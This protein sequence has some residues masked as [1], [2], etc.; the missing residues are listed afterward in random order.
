MNKWRLV[1]YTDDGCSLFQC[2]NCKGRWES[3]GAPGFTLDEVYHA[4]WKFCPIC[5]VRWNGSHRERQDEYGTRRTKVTNAI[6]RH[7]DAQFHAEWGQPWFK[8]QE[9][10]LAR[11]PH[12]WWVVEERTHSGIYKA[13]QRWEFGCKADGTIV[14][15]LRILA[16]KRKRLAELERH[17]Q[18]NAHEVRIVRVRREDWVAR[19]GHHLHEGAVVV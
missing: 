6:K 13:E 7:S 17:D 15:A 8:R 5:G 18:E 19:Y 9:I 11:G 2:L 16:I 4:D 1:R 3:R 12:F 14:S 10:E